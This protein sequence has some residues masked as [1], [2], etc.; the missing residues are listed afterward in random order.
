MLAQQTGKEKWVYLK[1]K[2][3]DKVTTSTTLTTL[4]NILTTALVM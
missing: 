1:G 4:D 3:N 2:E